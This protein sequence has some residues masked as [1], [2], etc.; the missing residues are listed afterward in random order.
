MPP[1][2]AQR[3][4][5]PIR[6]DNRMFLFFL[7]IFWGIF[8]KFAKDKKN[9]DRIVLFTWWITGRPHQKFVF[10][11][12]GLWSCFFILRFTLLDLSGSLEYFLF[13][14]VTPLVPYIVGI[15][16]HNIKEY[17]PIICGTNWITWWY[18]V[19]PLESL[20]HPF[21]IRWRTVVTEYY[22]RMEIN[23]FQLNEFCKLVRP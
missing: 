17:F 15:L 20:R 12:C 6:M 21:I 16:S 8:K 13:C 5:A 3:R 22:W 14:I 2:I 11:W 1:A 18:R 9:L 4:N 10:F 19:K 23:S 7:F